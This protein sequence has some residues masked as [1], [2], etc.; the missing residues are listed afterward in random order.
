MIREGRTHEIDTAI[1]T[2]SEHGMISMNRSLIDL[3]QR[4]EITIDDARTFATNPDG[5]AS[6]IQ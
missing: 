5:L 2:G 4:G 1:E 6:M 3:V